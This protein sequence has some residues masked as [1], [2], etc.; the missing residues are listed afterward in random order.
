MPVRFVKQCSVDTYSGCEVSSVKSVRKNYNYWDS[1]NIQYQQRNITDIKYINMIRNLESPIESSKPN[2]AGGRGVTTEVQE[3]D[4]GEAGRRGGSQAPT[5]S[6]NTSK[7]LRD[8]R[9]KDLAVILEAKKF[10]PWKSDDR[11]VNISSSF[12]RSP[13]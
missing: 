6:S 3:K 12:N 13:P 11:K 2:M 4:L 1:V 5:V 10:L 8:G 9:A 7:T